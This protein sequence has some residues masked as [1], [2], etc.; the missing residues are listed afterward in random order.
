MSFP[1]HDRFW[2]QTAEFLKAKI[3]PQDK[4]LAPDQF[5]W[6]FGQIYR[7]LISQKLL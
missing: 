1:H 7:Y 5:R 2:T 6:L 4:I 3:Q